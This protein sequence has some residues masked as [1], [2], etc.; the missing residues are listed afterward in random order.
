MGTLWCYG[1]TCLLKRLAIARKVGKNPTQLLAL[2]KATS[3]MVLPW[4]EGDQSLHTNPLTKGKQSSWGERSGIQVCRSHDL[5]HN[6]QYLPGVKTSWNIWSSSRL[7][8]SCP[9]FIVPLREPKE[10][11][12]I[13][14]WVCVRLLQASQ[15]AQPQFA[16]QVQVC[17]RAGPGGCPHAIAF[18]G[19]PWWE[20]PRGFGKAAPSLWHL[21]IHWHPFPHFFFVPSSPGICLLVFKYLHIS[22]LSFCW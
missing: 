1:S 21:Y 8:K 19:C 18:L 11:L 15:P 6:L 10:H 12:N 22:V 14:L 13:L 20:L 16:F 9:C 2:S 7:G 4:A 17:L 3:Q 5:Q